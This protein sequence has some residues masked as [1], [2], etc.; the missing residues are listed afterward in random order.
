MLPTRSRRPWVGCAQAVPSKHL[1]PRRLTPG[2]QEER[3]HS[4]GL[5]KGNTTLTTVLGKR[6]ERSGGAVDLQRRTLSLLWGASTQHL[7]TQSRWGPIPG[8]PSPRNFNC[9]N[10]QH[11]LPL[12]LGGFC[13]VMKRVAQ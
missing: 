13:L 6:R 5:E 10:R 12:W 4:L 2:R 9:L 1:P 8:F 11:R 3:D 7:L